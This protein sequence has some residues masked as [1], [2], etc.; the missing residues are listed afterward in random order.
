MDKCVTIASDRRYNNSKGGTIYFSIDNTVLLRCLGDNR[1]TGLCLQGA[2]CTL[3]SG[4]ASAGKTIGINAAGNNIVIDN[5]EI[6]GFTSS[7]VN[8]R[9][10]NVDLHN[11]YI[12]N[13]SLP[14]GYAIK[15]ESGTAAIK[16]NLFSNNIADVYSKNFDS[17]VI[18]NNIEVG[19]STDT[20]IILDGDEASIVEVANNSFL[21]DNTQY[22]ISNIKDENLKITNNLSNFSEPETL[23]QLGI[24]GFS[25]SKKPKEIAVI[26]DFTMNVFTGD[27]NAAFEY[28]I[29]IKASTDNSDD[30]LKHTIDAI[31]ELCGFSD[32]YDYLNKISITQDGKIYGAYTEEGASP[33]GG[34]VGMQG[35]KT[36]GDYI[37]NNLETLLDALEKAQS[38][39]VIFIKGDSIIDTTSLAEANTALEL[40]AGVTL[41]S[42][43][44]RILDDNTISTG[45]MLYS[46]TLTPVMINA[47]EGSKI[48]GLT[49]CGSDTWKHMSHIVRGT[50]ESG[51][52][53]Y[54]YSLMLTIGVNV[55]GD[56]F[57]I[58]NCEISGFSNSGVLLNNAK[59]AYI[60]NC[61]FHHYQR[62]GFGYGV[63]HSGASTS[64]IEYN[65]F[66]FDRHSVA[67]DGSAGSGYI[68]R[69]NVQMG[70]SIYHVFDAHGG[71]DRGDGTNIACD[72]VEMYNNTILSDK[73]PYKRRGVP[74]QYSKF[75]QNVVLYP[76]EYYSARLMEG[77]NMTFYDN[78]FGIKE[79]DLPDYNYDGGK[80]WSITVSSFDRAISSSTPNTILYSSDKCYY[81]SSEANLRY[82]Y[83]S[84]FAPNDDGTYRITEYGSNLDN[85][86]IMGYDE[87]VYIP[88]GGFV[89][90]F[91]SENSDMLSFYNYIAAEY[92]VI[93]NTT[94]PI[95]GGYKAEVQGDFGSE[96]AINI[97]AAKKQ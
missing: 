6:S 57:E 21:G 88:D 67:A 35:I 76:I 87:K 25:E 29:K 90:A 38:G 9:G 80:Q 72:Y 89:L 31:S 14:N 70:E 28:L 95:L 41:A 96:I 8:I 12:H 1:I 64:V 24:N 13:N 46:T 3:A 74:Q 58:S 63:C 65:L 16:S 92:S 68:A 36:T 40:K 43:R 5:C 93:Y 39:E 86:T 69:Y 60:H 55:K 83:L 33:I 91:T 32:Y 47:G 61:Y 59:D 97:T 85:G 34:G 79:I 23:K 56:N 77:E 17:V 53:D 26:P 52:T 2:N 45:A 10:E 18:Q 75:Y 42:D 4:Q 44:G 30:V 81:T 22:S 84:I 50:S 51:Y 94:L 37:V 78:I 71:N 27:K 19:T 20:L 82:A 7:A 15:I 49:L 48:D 73:I 66:N 11:N 54:Y 62:N